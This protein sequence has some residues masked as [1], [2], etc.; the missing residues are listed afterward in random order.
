MY[1]AMNNNI[2]FSKYIC[3]YANQV[4]SWCAS[5][6]LQVLVEEPT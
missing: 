1:S 5:A 6:E 2:V 3:V 4:C